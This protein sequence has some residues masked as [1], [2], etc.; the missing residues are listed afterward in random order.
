MGVVVGAKKECE[1]KSP[2]FFEGHTERARKMEE[3]RRRSKTLR[4][5]SNGN[6]F[7]VIRRCER[8]TAAH[9]QTP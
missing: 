4:E 9:F 5:T 1:A 7:G 3:Q 8:G 6:G 2:L